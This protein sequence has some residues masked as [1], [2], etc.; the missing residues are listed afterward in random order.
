[1]GIST[2]LWLRVKGQPQATNDAWNKRAWSMLKAS[3]SEIPAR[4]AA[5]SGGDSCSTAREMCSWWVQVAAAAVATAAAAAEPN[6]A[7]ARTIALAEA[8]IRR[9]DDRRC[10]RGAE[11]SKRGTLQ[12]VSR[13]DSICSATVERALFHRRQRLRK[14]VKC[15]EPPTA[16]ALIARAL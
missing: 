8:A 16:S 13:A 10:E 4:C 14:N 6:P 5:S 7:G 1:M 15:R 9:R 11:T 3:S 2:R 12:R